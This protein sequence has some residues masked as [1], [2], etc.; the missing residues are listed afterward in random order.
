M[1]LDE[2]MDLFTE[3][4]PLKYCLPKG[5]G[6]PSHMT[7]TED[8]N[9]GLCKKGDIFVKKSLGSAGSDRSGWVA[10]NTGFVL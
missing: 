10:R 1:F 2:K 8:N 5:R 3:I 9:H 7:I 4:K 6:S